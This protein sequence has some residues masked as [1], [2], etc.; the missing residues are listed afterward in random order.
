MGQFAVFRKNT[1]G[2]AVGVPPIYVA[3][4]SQCERGTQIDVVIAGVKMVYHVA[5]EFA[6]VEKGL[7][8]AMDRNAELKLKRLGAVFNLVKGAL[9]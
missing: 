1:D 2:K 9:L 7:M 8:M 3:G 4:I 5:E 6:A